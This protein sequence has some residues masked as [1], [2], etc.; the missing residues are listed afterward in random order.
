LIGSAWTGAGGFR[1]CGS[2]GPLAL[3]AAHMESF[4]AIG[5]T[6]AADFGLVGLFGIDA[7]A[8]TAGVWTV[9]VNPRYTASVEV[10]ERATDMPSIALHAAACEH[11]A[12]AERVAA[13]ERDTLHGKAIVFAPRRFEVADAWAQRMLAAS[14]ADA[15]P[16]GDVP[17][18]GGTIEAGWPI[19]TVFAEGR[20][21]RA[22]L[23][24]LAQRAESVLRESDAGC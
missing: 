7:V 6:L 16:V 4:R 8:N 5:A 24:A 19:V 9:E 1:Y 20:D 12:L 17:S 22:V 18:A 14:A 21:E 11:G 10:L 23:A 15:P 3:A 2:I 13:T